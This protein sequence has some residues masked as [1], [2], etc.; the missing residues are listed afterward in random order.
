[1]QAYRCS[2]GE[3]FPFFSFFPFSGETGRRD[4]RVH[5]L[6]GG[7]KMSVVVSEV[8]LIHIYCEIEGVKDLLG[9]NEG[10]ASSVLDYVLTELDG[11]L[12]G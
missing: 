5:G 7:I 3:G 8:K 4:K 1:M 2:K 9:D 12:K 11:I 10:Q 6:L